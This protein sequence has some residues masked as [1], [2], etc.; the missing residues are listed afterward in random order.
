MKMFHRKK[1]RPKPV[2]VELQLYESKLTFRLPDGSWLWFEPE[3]EK[4]MRDLLSAVHRA[5]HS[6][7]FADV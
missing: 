1:N 7:E 5:H 4:E 6:T 2:Q 3:T